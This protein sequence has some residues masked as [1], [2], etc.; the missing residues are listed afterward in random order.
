MC[1][2]FGMGRDI[3]STTIPNEFGSTR[4]TAL[5]VRTGVGNT[6]KPGQKVAQI[7]NLLFA[8]LQYGKKA[9]VV[10]IV[11]GIHQISRYF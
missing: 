1:V 11:L 4:R 6:K 3:I 2:F 9:Y 7:N 8:I 5:G 10:D